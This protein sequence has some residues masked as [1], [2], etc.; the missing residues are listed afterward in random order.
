MNGRDV[1]KTALTATQNLVSWYLSDLADAD[2]LVRPVLGANHIAWQLGHLTTSEIHLVK[3]QLPDAVYPELPAGFVDQ[4]KP[5]AA[6]NDGAQNFRT[7]GEY[8]DQ[9]NKVRSTT[10]KLL[11]QLSDQ[12][13]DRPTRGNMAKFAPTLGAL[14]TL[15]SNHTLMHAGQFSVVRRKLEKPILF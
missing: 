9:F 4:H 12:D 8:L 13:L 10:V 11:D 5:T 15:I 3:E 1:I 6:K 14:L 7:K 2:L